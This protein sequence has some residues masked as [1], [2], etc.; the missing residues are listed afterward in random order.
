MHQLMAPWK[1]NAKQLS[2]DH[3]RIPY[4]WAANYQAKNGK[5]YGPLA[6]W[7]GGK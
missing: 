3:V 6:P 7:D 4:A 5:A 2:T 1:N